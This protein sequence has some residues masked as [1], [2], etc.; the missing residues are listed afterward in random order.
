MR[1]T[2]RLSLLV[3]ATVLFSGCKTWRV[4]DGPTPAEFVQTEHPERVQVRRTDNTTLELYNPTVAGDS[5]K[6]F[7]TELAIRPI[8]IPLTEVRTVAIRR[9][10]LGRTVLFAVALGGGLFIYDWLMSLNEGI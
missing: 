10:S 2:A 6:G 1:I 5:L 4:Q 9:F 8:T 3:L 7:P